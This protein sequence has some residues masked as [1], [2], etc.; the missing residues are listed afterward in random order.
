MVMA[1]RDTLHSSTFDLGTTVMVMA[2]DFR[3]RNFHLYHSR[4]IVSG[5]SPAPH[6]DP[7]QR[8]RQ[9]DDDDYRNPRD[10]I[11]KA[12]VGPLAHERALVDQQ[13]HEDQDHRQQ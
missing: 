4:T 7:H 6:R 8:Q 10:G 5:L 12:R 2:T 1:P 11:V 13:D 9:P 3:H